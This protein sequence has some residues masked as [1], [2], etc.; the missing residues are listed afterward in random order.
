[1]VEHEEQ[2]TRKGERKAAE[3]EY[4]RKRTKSQQSQERGK[5]RPYVGREEE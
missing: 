3:K 2:R 1:M 4:R 5:E